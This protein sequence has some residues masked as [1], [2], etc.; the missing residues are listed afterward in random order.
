MLIADAF[1][2]R[3]HFRPPY[4]CRHFNATLP[5]D[6]FASLMNAA[7]VRHVPPVL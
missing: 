1:I 2:S 3:R 4:R 5:L 6:Y 7:K